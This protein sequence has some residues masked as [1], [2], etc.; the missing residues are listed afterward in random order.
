M[1]STQLILIKILPNIFNPTGFYFHSKLEFLLF[2]MYNL[3]EKINAL[4]ALF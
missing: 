2:D 3:N 1:L 4:S